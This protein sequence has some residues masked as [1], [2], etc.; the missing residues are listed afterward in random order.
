MI[1]NKREDKVLKKL[2]IMVIKNLSKE[3]KLNKVIYILFKK[4]NR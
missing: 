1:F 2:I 4:I 3:K